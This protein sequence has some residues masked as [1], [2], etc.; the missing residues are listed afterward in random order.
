MYMFGFGGVFE[1]SLALKP[2]STTAGDIHDKLNDPSV[3]VARARRLLLASVLS[4]SEE[5]PPAIQDVH[6]PV[7]MKC[8]GLASTRGRKRKLI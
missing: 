6:L 2:I 1:D 8:L 5:A 3:E 4:L 7:G